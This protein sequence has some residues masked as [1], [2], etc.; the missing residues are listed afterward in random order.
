MTTITVLGV[1]PGDPDLL[2][3]KAKEAIIQADVVAGF[4]TVLKPVSRWI[5]GEALPMRYRDQE[6]VLDVVAARAAEGK[7]CVVCAWGDLNFSARELVERVERRADEIVLIPGISSVQ[8]ACSRLGLYM[9]ESIFITLHAR[10]GNDDSLAELVDVLNVGRRNVLLLPRPY[11]LMPAGIAKILL[12]EGIPAKT[13][14]HVLQRLCHDDESVQDYILGAL[15]QE[16]A[17]FSDLTIMV[18][19]KAL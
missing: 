4:E 12:E 15:A 18:F 1:G 14:M 10:A 5:K 8:V 16:E 17:E 13:P 11:E 2:T 9:E 3:L 19:P 6:D 7:K